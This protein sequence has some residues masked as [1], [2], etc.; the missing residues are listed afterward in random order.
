MNKVYWDNGFFENQNKE[1]TRK[2]I[3]NERR[4]YLLNEQANNYAEIITG[5]DGYPTLKYLKTSEAEKINEQ[6]ELLKTKLKDTD[7]QAIKFSE[8]ELSEEEYQP[9]KEQRRAWRQEINLLQYQLSLI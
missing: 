9:I 5:E 1:G 4:L 2:E 8:G 6:I 7:Y 3:T